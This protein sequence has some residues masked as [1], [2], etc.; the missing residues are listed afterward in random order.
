MRGSTLSLHGVHHIRPLTEDS[1]AQSAGPL[2]IACHRVEYRGEGQESEDAR[3][4]GKIV[5]LDGLGEGV[6][7]EI[8]VL[9]RPS[10]R[11]GDLIPE[12]GSG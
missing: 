4:P 2:G 6:T 8:A 9:L 7:G 3:I 5:G 1:V 10:R 11:V 12:R